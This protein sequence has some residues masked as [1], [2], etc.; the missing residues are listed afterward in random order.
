MKAGRLSGLFWLAGGLISI[1]GSFLLGLG[2]LR[3][4]GPGLFPFFAG[5]FVSLMATVDYFQSF[6]REWEIQ[7]KLSALWKGLNWHRPLAIS[8]LSL[9]YILALERIGFLLSSF[10]LLFTL[11]KGVEK[12]SWRKSILIPA[13]TLGTIFLLI[14][15]LLKGTLPKG[16]LG[17]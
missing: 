3:E 15:F 10:L 9:G 14:N 13:I 4:P 17:F 6:L 5:C 1:Y 8:L 2:T 11:F 12:L 7:D 16:V